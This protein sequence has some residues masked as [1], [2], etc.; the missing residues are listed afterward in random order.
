MKFAS[1]AFDRTNGV[2]YTGCHALKIWQAK[3]D[4]K[5]EIQAL[6]V[7]TLSKQILKERKMVEANEN[8]GKANENK[9]GRI[10]VTKTSELVDVL[11]NLADDMH[12]IVTVDSENLVR[13]WST[14]HNQ[15][16]F[17]Y[18]VPMR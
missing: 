11:I 2:L 16:T 13:A 7:E 6:Q 18:K 1:S 8:K 17:S 12:F 3:V 15:T 10:L 14:K 5:V 4:S 9:N